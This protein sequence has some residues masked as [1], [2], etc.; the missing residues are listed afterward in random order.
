MAE[1]LFVVNVPVPEVDEIPAS[2]KVDRLNS[3]PELMVNTPLTVVLVL[4]VLVPD[5][6]MV[7]LLKVMAG[8]VWVVPLKLTVELVTV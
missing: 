2:V 1:V 8:M 7:R 6:S 4:A 3:V 5:P